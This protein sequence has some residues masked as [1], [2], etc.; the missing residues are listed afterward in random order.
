MATRSRNTSAFFIAI[1]ILLVGLLLLLFFAGKRVDWRESYRENDALPYGSSLLQNLLERSITQGEFK[2]ISD[3]LKN[4]LP[5]A[6]AAPKSS[7]VFIGRE[8]YFDEDDLQA[9]SNFITDGN[10]GYVISQSFSALF[11]STFLY[12][13]ND[14]LT[15]EELNEDLF[16][17]ELVTTTHKG[18]DRLG[19]ELDTTVTLT[20]VNDPTPFEVT[21]FSDNKVY[22]K[23]WTHFVDD[24]YTPDENPVEVLGRM[25]NASNFIE[26]PLG[27]GKLYLH[28]SPLAFT[29]FWLS[30][31]E[32]FNYANQVFAHLGDGDLLW[33]TFHREY[34]YMSDTPW[35]PPNYEHEDG[36]LAFILSKRE[37]ALAWFSLLLAGLL[38]LIFGARRV[39]RPI[40]VVTPPQNTS[41][42][43]AETIGMMY[44]GESEHHRLSALKMRLFHAFVRERYNLRAQLH[45]EDPVTFYE[46]LSEKSH[47]PASEIEA[48]FDIYAIIEGRK[49]PDGAKLIRLHNA[50]EKF[51][52]H[53]R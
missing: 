18:Y 2:Y 46:R 15:F 7:Y 49:D 37:L 32:G 38:Y 36:M 24:I 45:Q 5:E 4:S 40:P 20:L 29:N 35:R 6:E 8:T 39:Q 3:T 11:L 53:A 48:I 19:S 17:D 28:T 10:T 42:E 34:R 47:V 52:A 12:R 27:K 41:L 21:Y 16:S 30:R 50:I 33:D 14:E 51:Y 22:M 13:A 44:R 23:T 25:N 1:A 31:K 43:F 9:L 26:V